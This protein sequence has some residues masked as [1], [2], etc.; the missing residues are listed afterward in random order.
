MRRT[1]I[2]VRIF[3]IYAIS[4]LSI[5]VLTFFLVRM[6]SSRVME[7]TLSEYLMSA[8]DL[9]ADMLYFVSEKRSDT[10]NLYIDYNGGYL[11]IDDDFLNILNDV[12]SALYTGEGELLYGDGSLTLAMSK[13]PF[14][15]ARLYKTVIEN[16][17]YIVYDRSFSQEDL[18]SLW[19]RGV[20]PVTQSR[21]Q[22]IQIT[23]S[24][25]AFLPLILLLIFLISLGAAGTILS[26]IRK[27]EETASGIVSGDDL[28]TRIPEPKAN[29][30]LSHLAKSYNMMFDRL[31]ASFERERNFISDASHELR[32]PLSVIMTE[33]E[34]ALSSPKTGEQYVDSLGVIDRQARR[35]KRL[36]TDMLDLSRME[37]GHQKYPLAPFDLSALCMEV[38][39]DMSRLMINAITLT[40]DIAD[41]VILTGNKKL[42]ERMLI[43]LID[44]A[45]KYG[46]KGGHTKV[47]LSPDGLLRVSDDGIGMDELQQAKVFDRFYR[48]EA[49]REEIPG[50]GLGLSLVRQ[51]VN[52]HGGSIELSSTPGAGTTFS[53]TFRYVN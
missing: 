29:D 36:V 26:P 50:Y 35:M 9:N 12:Q 6:V 43:N 40:Y 32:T 24:V 39:E 2:R 21:L 10:T 34:Y 4:M 23:K 47:S 37:Q 49:S 48:A 46:K 7:K 8:V 18:S 38:C 51:I 30:E 42:I 5:L 20:V 14:T 3:L 25:L 41:G 13:E 27:M 11:C 28:R 31:L 33:S 1:S 19:I 45:Y 44:N 22:I 52:Y 15:T 53:I 17:E 16:E